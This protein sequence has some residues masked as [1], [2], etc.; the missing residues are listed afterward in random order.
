MLNQIRVYDIRRSEY[1]SGK[2]NK[3]TYKNLEGKL[4]KFMKITSSKR[5]GM[6][7]RAKCKEIIS[8]NNKNVKEK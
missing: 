1:L 7:T 5:R 8:N 2:I 3:N 4:E 6:P